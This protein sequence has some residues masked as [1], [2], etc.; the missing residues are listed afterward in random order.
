MFVNLCYQF[1]QHEII[2]HQFSKGK[3]DLC[4]LHEVFWGPKLEQF[5]FFTKINATLKLTV[6]F[7]FFLRAPQ[8][9]THFGQ[10]SWHFQGKSTVFFCFWEIRDAYFGWGLV[11]QQNKRTK[12]GTFQS[13]VVSRALHF[14][15][16]IL[17]SKQRTFSDNAEVCCWSLSWL[18]LSLHSETF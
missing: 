12:S 14:T 11:I 13:R 2:F 3:H 16:C 5:T 9:N 10:M 17:K 4:S 7:L 8:L 1:R 18:H 15:F 6:L